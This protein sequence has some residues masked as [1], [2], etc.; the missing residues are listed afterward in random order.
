M[1]THVIALSLICL[2][3]SSCGSKDTGVIP[4]HQIKAM[5]DAK[6]IEAQ[7]QQNA[8]ARLKKLD[9]ETP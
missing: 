8:D 4:K 3:L 2:A 9:E 6:A 7:L 5:D 1:K